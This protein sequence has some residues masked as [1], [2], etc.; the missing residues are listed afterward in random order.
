M[1]G[2]F[3]PRTPTTLQPPKDDPITLD[4]LRRADGHNHCYVAI[5]GKVFD[6][7]GNK[8]YLPGGSYHV[9]AGRDASRALA[10]TSV[11]IEDVRPEWEDLDAKEKKTLDDWMIFFSKRYNVVGTVTAEGSKV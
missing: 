5:K 9:F 8:A 11:K 6:V 1:S 2:K 7:S 4:E 3:E 10:L